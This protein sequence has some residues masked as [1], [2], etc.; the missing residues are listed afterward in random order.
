MIWIILIVVSLMVSAIN[1]ICGK[2]VEGLVREDDS[3]EVGAFVA[4]SMFPVTNIFVLLIAIGF[5]LS[6]YI[7]NK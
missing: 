4:I 3:E 2:Y 7:T 5:M 6:N 1:I